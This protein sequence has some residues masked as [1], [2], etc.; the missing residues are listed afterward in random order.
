M[1]SGT[2]DKYLTTPFDNGFDAWFDKVGEA[3]NR[4]KEVDG[5]EPP[6]GKEISDNWELFFEPLIMR[7]SIAGG[8]LTKSGGCNPS[9]AAFVLSRRWVIFKK[10]VLPYLTN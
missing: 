7:L 4:V 5:I 3:L 2:L 1:N 8:S 6:T 10:N 9:F